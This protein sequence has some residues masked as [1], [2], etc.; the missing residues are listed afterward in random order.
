VCYTLCQRCH[1]NRSCPPLAAKA[2][3]VAEK[4]TGVY[5]KSRLFPFH[6]SN[7]FGSNGKWLWWTT[8]ILDIAI[9]Y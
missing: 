6:L 9:S 3:E 2:F 8:E 1:F 5:E 7:Q 4:R